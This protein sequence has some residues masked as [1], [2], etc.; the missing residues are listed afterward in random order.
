MITPPPSNIL[1]LENYHPPTDPWLSVLFQDEHLMVVNKP[2]GLLSVP[3]K[4]AEHHD[5]LMTRIQRDYPV[6]ESVHRLDLST[7]GVIAVALTKEA[8]RELK[9]QF[10]ERETKKAYI[11]RVWGHMAEDYGI[12]DLPLI[13][14]YPNRPK[15]KV[16]HETG[17]KALTQYE[18]L[19]WDTDG[20]TRVKLRPVTG[21]S[22]QLRVH[23]LAL[24]HPILGDKFYAHPEA[25]AM[26]PRLQLHAQELSIYHPITDEPMTFSCEPDF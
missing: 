4:A 24:G 20:T 17:K 18:V 13:C 11:A 7:S 25:L 23:L 10:R 12:I 26:A 14:D 5:S 8:E 19:S 3:G 9:R 16:C 15:Q 22:H 21:R 1:P 6:A 2:S